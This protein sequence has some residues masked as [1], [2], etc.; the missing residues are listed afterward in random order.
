MRAM[1]NEILGLLKIRQ[2]NRAREVKR[3][4]EREEP[5][6]SRT[7]VEEAGMKRLRSEG[8]GSELQ[9]EGM[10]LKDPG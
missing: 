1:E 2:E 4:R 6:G 8:L 5:G 3:E 9:R 10:N 7:T